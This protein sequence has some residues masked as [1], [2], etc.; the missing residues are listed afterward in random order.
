MERKKALEVLREFARKSPRL[1]LTLEAQIRAESVLFLEARAEEGGERRSLRVEKEE[2]GEGP[3]AF[4]F[5]EARAEEGTSDLVLDHPALLL[6]WRGEEFFCFP[7]RLLEG[8]ALEEL[9]A[10]AKTL[11][12]LL[13]ALE[14]PL[15][16]QAARDL[17][18]LSALL[19]DPRPFAWGK[20]FLVAKR[21]GEAGI[22]S[23][24]GRRF[25]VSS[26]EEEGEGTLVLRLFGREDSWVRARPLWRGPKGFF[27]TPLLFPEEGRFAGS[28]FPPGRP[29]TLGGLF[30]N[31]LLEGPGEDLWERWLGVP[32][33]ALEALRVGRTRE[34]LRLLSLARLEGT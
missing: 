4:L 32:R 17:A 33:E 1:S 27:L 23:G 30:A 14:E 16:L 34:A 24:D 28:P 12:L 7:R 10:S 2:E 29:A 26:I 6:R 9:K 5:L 13:E 22:A 18:E 15:A 8:E 19:E 21:K 11:S 20:R 31:P 3:K 25:P